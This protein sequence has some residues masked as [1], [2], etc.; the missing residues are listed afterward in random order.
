M[1]FT[2]LSYFQWLPLLNLNSTLGTIFLQVQQVMEQGDFEKIITYGGSASVVSVLMLGL[3]HLGKHFNE[4]R[5]DAKENE[6]TLEQRNM[7]L[8]EEKTQLL[9]EHI[10]MLDRQND[11]LITVNK[12]NNAH[13]ER[14]LD[15]YIA[16][17]EKQRTAFANEHEKQRQNYENIYTR[18]E[19]KKVQ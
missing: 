12:E 14:M 16:E 5:K 8:E 6:K 1:F 11:K 15:K 7:K 9:K 2:Q 13:H 18:L 17:N 19:N 4:V 10:T 3:Y